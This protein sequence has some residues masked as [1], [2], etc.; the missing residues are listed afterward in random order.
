MDFFVLSNDLINIYLRNLN[1]NIF[2]TMF[3]H[4]IFKVLTQCFSSLNLNIVIFTLLSSGD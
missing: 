3:P 1:I 2:T 4:K